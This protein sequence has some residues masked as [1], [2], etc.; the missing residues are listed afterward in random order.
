MYEEGNRKINFNW[1]SLA[2]KLGIIAVIVFIICLIITK[3]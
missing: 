1:G 2:I 3:V